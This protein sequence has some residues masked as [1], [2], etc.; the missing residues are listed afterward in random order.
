MTPRAGRPPIRAL[1]WDW[2]RPMP[3]ASKERRREYKAA[4]HAANAEKIRERKA[5]NKQH[6]REREAAYR[7]A[8]KQHIRERDAAYHAANREKRNAQKAAYHAANR[9]RIRER[10]AA[11]HAANP[12]YGRWRKAHQTAR[13][14]GAPGTFEI[15]DIERLLEQQDHR[16]PACGGDLRALPN[17][18]VHIDHKVPLSR[19]GSNWPDNIHVLCEPCNLSK[20][21]KAW[22]EFIGDRRA[23]SVA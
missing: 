15:A 19:G 6:I 20:G 12:H 2:G 8:N 5:A 16:C 17:V 13:Q 14:H 23:Q 22:D 1:Y 7:A 9:E 3:Y 18:E 11:Y 21:T 10:R 4:Y